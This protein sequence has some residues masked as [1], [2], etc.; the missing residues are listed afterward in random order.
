M[1]FARTDINNTLNAFAQKPRFVSDMV[2]FLK[3]DVTTI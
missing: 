2:A 3:Q 1:K